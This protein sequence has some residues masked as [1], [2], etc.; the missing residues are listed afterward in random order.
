M[1]KTAIS[2]ATHTWNPATGCSKP[3]ETDPV[4]GKRYISPECEHCYAETLSIRRGWTQK[5]WTEPNAKEN[6]TIHP[7]RL[8]AAFKFN[9][10]REQL[11]TVH[12]KYPIRVFV[13][14]MS[15]L[16]HREVPDDFIHEVFH[17]MNHPKNYGRVFQVLTKRPERAAEWP[18]PWGP[19]IW[20]GTTSGDART[21]FRIDHLRRC[22]A[23][24][25]FI[26]VEPL[27]TSM[28]PIN[29][30]GI[31]QLIVGGES[32]PGFRPMQMHWARELR[33]AC[34]EQKVPFFFK[35]SDSFRTETRCYLVETDGR[36]FE[37]RQM[38]HDFSPPVEVEPDNPAFHRKHFQILT[39]A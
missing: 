1:G 16:F 30:A 29:L 9:L 25:R 32:G 35:Q 22:P 6:V 20:M 7:D 23:Q 31:H 36:C 8:K 27:L 37:W 19:N 12:P 33:D 28:V 14:S 39:G 17:V 18:G 2:W 11:E 10:D 24:V 26:S 4:T 21:R 3:I 13:N 5:P 15:D 34:L 38:P